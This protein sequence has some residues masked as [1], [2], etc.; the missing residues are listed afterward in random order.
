MTGI[1]RLPPQELDRKIVDKHMVQSIYKA[2]YGTVIVKSIFNDRN[3]FP[4]LLYR[5]I[6][7]KL[8]PS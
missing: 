7:G 5:I 6:L 2:G 4:D 1:Y 3:Q 8:N